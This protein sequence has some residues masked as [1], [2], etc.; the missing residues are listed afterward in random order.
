MAAVALENLDL[1]NDAN[2]QAYYTL[3]DANDDK[4][5]NNLTNANSVTFTAAK[6]NNGADGGTTDGNRTLRITNNLGYT[7]GAYSISLWFKIHA[8]LSGSDVYH[9]ICYLTD[10]GAG[11]DTGLSL[12]YARISGVNQVLFGRVRWGVAGVEIS[13]S[14]NLG[15]TDFHHLALTY[16]GTT[17]IGYL[18]GTA[19]GDVAASGNGTG[20]PATMMILLG[21]SNDITANNALGIVDDAA[22]FNRVLTPDEVSLIYNGPGISPFPTHFNP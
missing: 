18:N 12:V 9:A 20:N 19:V 2:L 10:G 6:F 7:G 5:S 3:E 15:T 8:E 1:F 17:L 14:V 22:F 13:H 4:N 21:Q 16:N 11:S